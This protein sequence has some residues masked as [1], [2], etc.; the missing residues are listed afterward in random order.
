MKELLRQLL[1][2]HPMSF[3]QSVETFDKIMT[4]QVSEAELAAMLTLIEVRGPTVDEIAGAAQVMRQRLTPV[5]APSGLTL[6]DTCGTGGDHSSTLNISTAAALVAAAAGRPR[7]VAVAKHGNRSITSQSGSSQVLETLGVTLT[8]RP[9]TLTRCLDEAGICF[10]FAPSHHPAMKYAMPVRKALGFRTIFNLVGPLTNPAGTRRQLMGVANQALT[11]TMAEA[12]LRLDA[13]EVMVACGRL[14]EG[15]MDE[16]STVGPTHI[17]HL[18]NGKI[19]TS[20]IDPASLGISPADP[21]SL[22]VDSPSAS[23]GVIQSVLTGERGPARDI[24]CL[25]AAAALMVGGLADT[26][27]TGTELAAAAIDDGAAGK[28][29]KKLAQITQSD[30]SP[31]T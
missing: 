30:A 28:T 27:A 12:L 10:C 7:G 2:C 11:E 16:L 21:A 18:R 26:L 8:N 9:E 24:V 6:I 5:D 31:T 17:S 3:A 20:R 25:N 23:A 15:W 1:A 13:E 22:Q 4:G 19:E 14:G 29:L